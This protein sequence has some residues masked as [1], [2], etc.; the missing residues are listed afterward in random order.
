ML[1]GVLVHVERVQPPAIHAMLVQQ[2]GETPVTGQGIRRDDDVRTL[3]LHG[4]FDSEKDVI[5]PEELDIDVWHHA[6]A[7]VRIP[8]PGD[9]LALDGADAGD[10]LAIAKG[11]KRGRFKLKRG[12]LLLHKQGFR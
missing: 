12:G 8:V 6:D 5:Q 10:L 2:V 3:L 4:G 7:V 11:D 1:I 9:V